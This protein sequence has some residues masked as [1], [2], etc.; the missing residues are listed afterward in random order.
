[1]SQIPQDGNLGQ[2]V[3]LLTFTFYHDITIEK[4]QHSETHLRAEN[5]NNAQVNESWSIPNPNISSQLSVNTK[6]RFLLSAD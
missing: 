5:I 3:A 1:M 4:I 2:N 6:K